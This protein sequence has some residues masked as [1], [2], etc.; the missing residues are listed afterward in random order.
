[1]LS[2]EVRIISNHSLNELDARPCQ[3][4]F[5]VAQLTFFS[6]S[7]LQK[8]AALR[9]QGWRKIKGDGNCYYRAVII[10]VLEQLILCQDSKERE[11]R[12]SYLVGQLE[13]LMG[14]P[15]ILDTQS[16]E[17]VIAIL[18]SAAKNEALLTTYAL[19]VFLL[20]YDL[21]LVSAMRMASVR[22]FTSHLDDKVLSDITL[23]DALGSDPKEYTDTIIKMGEYAFGPVVQM[24][25]LNSVLGANLH[26][27]LIEREALIP[28]ENPNI[29]AKIGEYPPIEVY[30]LLRS[31]H[32]D[33][34]QTETTYAALKEAEQVMTP[35]DRYLTFF[36]P[37][38]I[39]KNIE[40]RGQNYR[41]MLSV[42]VSLKACASV[43][44]VVLLLAGFALLGMA[45]LGALPAAL[46]LGAGILAIAVSSVGLF[47]S[48]SGGERQKEEPFELLLEK[49]YDEEE[50]KSHIETAW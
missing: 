3:S 9:L 40:N 2:Q 7:I 17:E 15:G 29:A 47:A 35:E 28:I 4:V 12:F 16:L 11:A 49:N 21:V 37:K 20:D 25:L 22:V 41:F 50:S 13:L 10:G 46:G 6:P 48:K 8:L 44:C 24:C 39:K 27:C 45:T 34:L 23:R 1:M 30:L 43:I 18:K 31:E 33:L 42:F 38:T 26:V 5:D 19:E 36:R 32:Y 14:D